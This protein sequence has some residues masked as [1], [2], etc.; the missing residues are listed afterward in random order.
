MSKLTDTLTQ[1]DG[2]QNVVGMLKPPATLE[3]ARKALYKA[4]EENVRP[5]MGRLGAQA[6]EAWHVVSEGFEHFKKDAK[7]CTKQFFDSMSKSLEGISA[8]VVKQLRDFLESAGKLI[9][10]VTT[11]GKQF[12][13]KTWKEFNAAVSGL[14]ATLKKE[15]GIEAPKSNA[16]QR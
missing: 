14:C 9:E 8:P 1:L 13:E 5:L 7:V 4:W 10:S 16:R 15:L 3:A 2:V 12:G 11:K 6:G